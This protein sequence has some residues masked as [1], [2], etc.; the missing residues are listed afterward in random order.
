[1]HVCVFVFF[2]NLQLCCHGG[3]KETDRHR[4][5]ASCDGRCCF[6]CRCVPGRLQ[7]AVSICEN[8][9]EMII[10]VNIDASSFY[11]AEVLSFSVVCRFI[12]LD[13]FILVVHLVVQSLTYLNVCKFVN[14]FS[15]QH[16]SFDFIAY[17]CT[18][19]YAPIFLMSSV[20]TSIFSL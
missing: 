4:E 6:C 14:I 1:M 12:S 19:V 10:T 3:G 20:L 18:C 13:Y 7:Y 8:A 5:Q 17:P 9:R 15:M 16:I 11:Q 2:P